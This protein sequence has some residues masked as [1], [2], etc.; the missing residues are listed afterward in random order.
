M[1]DLEKRIRKVEDLL[2][3]Y[4]ENDYLVYIRHILA[5]YLRLI[6]IYVEY[7][8]ISPTIIFP[9]IKDSISREIIEILFSYGSLNTSQ[10]TDE[11]KKSRGK[12]S[13]RIVREKLNN[14]VEAGIVE[15]DER[16]NERIYSISEYAVKK[17]LKVL[18]IN[19]KGDVHKE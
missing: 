7:G 19:I 4:L 8:K 18:G 1:D 16:K 11:L 10:I 2:E 3:K 17:W 5:S 13:R 6:N 12:A 14:L 15:C 9:E